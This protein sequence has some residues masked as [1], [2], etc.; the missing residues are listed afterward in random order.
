[1]DKRLISLTESYRSGLLGRRDF[2]QKVLLMVGSPIIAG[3]VLQQMGF[4]NEIVKE[5]KAQDLPIIETN[6]QY[7]AGDKAVDYFLAKPSWNGPLPTMIVIHENVGL[8]DFV[9]NV[10][11]KFARQGFLAMA[12]HVLS[13]QQTAIAKHEEW[14]LKTLE[15]GVAEVPINEIDALNYGYDYLAQREDVDSNHIGSV[16]FCWGGARSFTLATAN[17]QLWAAIVFYGSTP[18]FDLLPNIT[19]PVLGLYGANDNNSPTS[20]TGRAAET[21]REMRR[22]NKIFEWEVY[23]RAPHGF[24]RGPDRVSL[25]E[26]RPARLA[27]DLLLDFLERYY[28]RSG[29]A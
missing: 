13:F 22:L 25:S 11:R 18:P 15:T 19:A 23:N 2:I 17:Q 8:T 24:F 6:G 4:D 28:D 12:P 3:T 29:R 27:W 21:A 7:P 5:V 14:M 16:G 1:M 26:D 20:I 9:R 10:S